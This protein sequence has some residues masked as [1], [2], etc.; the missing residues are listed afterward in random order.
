MSTVALPSGFMPATCRLTLS[1]NQRVNAAPFGGSEQA[2]DLLND[3]WL[4]SCEL[5][6]GLFADGAWREAFIDSFRGQVNVSNLYHFARP[7]PAGT[8]RGTLTL[9]ASAAQGASIIRVTGCTPSDGSLLAGDMLGIG[10]LLLR[11]ASNCAAVAGVIT[12]P[13]VNR[14]R[15]AQSSGAAVTW[16]MPTAPFRLLSNTGVDYGSGR[17]SATSF[18]FGEAI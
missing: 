13:I 5:R 18:E 11:V 7:I 17:V 12:V 3:R 8:V 10:G 4:L 1:T 14:L 2:I 6:E 15:A 16:N 9:V